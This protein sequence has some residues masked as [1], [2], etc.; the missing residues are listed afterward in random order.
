LRLDSQFQIQT[1]RK[2]VKN[3]KRMAVPAVRLLKFE[4]RADLL[5]HILHSHGKAAVPA[6]RLIKFETRADLLGHLHSQGARWNELNKL[7]KKKK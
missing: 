6:L 7:N 3:S 2:Q 5:G 4:T 1:G